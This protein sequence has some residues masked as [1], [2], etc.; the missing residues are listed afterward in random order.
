M[1]L[2][3]SLATFDTQTLQ[4]RFVVARV[5]WAFPHPEPDSRKICITYSAFVQ[6][7]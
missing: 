1:K 6:E 7:L 4:R 5:W 3:S 2:W